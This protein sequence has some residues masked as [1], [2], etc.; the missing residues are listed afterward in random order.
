MVEIIKAISSFFSSLFSVFSK[1]SET[2]SQVVVI[3]NSITSVEEMLK[4]KLDNDKIRDA[5]IK[6]VLDNHSQAHI[7]TLG[8]TIR[9]IYTRY[10]DAKV[11][12]LREKETIITMYSAYKNLIGDEITTVEALYEEMKEW[13]VSIP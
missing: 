4:T 3:K 6:K 7:Q 12:P 13:E 5:E 8:N 1:S 9:L 11:L 2:Q 10:H